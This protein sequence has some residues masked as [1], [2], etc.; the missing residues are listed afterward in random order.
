[1]RHLL[2]AGAIV[3]TSTVVAPAQTQLAPIT[4]NPVTLHFIQAAPIGEA[5]SVVGRLAGITIEFDK[6]V[7]EDMQRA[8][9][10]QEMR[11][12]DVSV[13]QAIS[14]LTSTNGLTYTIIGPKTVRISK[15]V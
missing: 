7:T 11:M 6:T 8:S 9:L 15:K 3:L 12:R 10:T 14:A 4:A 1:M 13:E 2:I 5:L